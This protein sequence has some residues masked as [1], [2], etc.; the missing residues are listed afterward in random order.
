[1]SRG[2]AWRR[3][4]ETTKQAASARVEKI[5]ENRSPGLKFQFPGEK[6]WKDMAGRSNKIRRGRQLGFEYPRK[7]Q[8]DILDEHA[9][10]D[11]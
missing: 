9:S 11:E 7:T 6:R 10:S 4:K 2:K 3:S 1:M 5:R 8:R